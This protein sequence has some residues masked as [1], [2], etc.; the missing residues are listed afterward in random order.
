M[1]GVQDST[2]TV[3]VSSAG[4]LGSLPGAMLGINWCGQNATGCKQIPA[5]E[6]TRELAADLYNLRIGSIN[7]LLPKVDG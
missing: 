2:L 4:G 1:A 5:A 6:L 7:T 3:A